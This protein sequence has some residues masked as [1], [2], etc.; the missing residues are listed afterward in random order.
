MKKIKVYQI[1]QFITDPT[2]LKSL[3]SFP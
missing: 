3:L 1:D 2:F